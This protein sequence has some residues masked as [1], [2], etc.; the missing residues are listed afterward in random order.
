MDAAAVSPVVLLTG[1]FLGVV[2]LIVLQALDYIYEPTGTHFLI[3]ATASLGLALLWCVG[4]PWRQSRMLSTMD[5]VFGHPPRKA[6]DDDRV[7]RTK[8]GGGR[9]CVVS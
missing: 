8:V 4:I 6:P 9:T 2:V 1:V 7:V 3:V 5:R